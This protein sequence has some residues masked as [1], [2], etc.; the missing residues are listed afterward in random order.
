MASGRR[1]CIA[2]VFILLTGFLLS[3]CTGWHS[4]IPDSA[5]PGEAEARQ[6]LFEL[7]R[8]NEGLRSFKGLGKIRITHEDASRNIRLAW[9]GATGGKLRLE[10]LSVLGQPIATLASDGQW[11][12]IHSYARQ[13]FYKTKVSGAELKNLIGIPISSQDVIDLLTGHPPV[14]SY[15]H[16]ALFRDATW[17]GMIIELK[18]RWGNLSERLYLSDAKGGVSKIEVY[19]RFKSLVYACVFEEMNAVDGFRVPRILTIFAPKGKSVQLTIERYWANA[20]VA[21]SMFVLQRP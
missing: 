4:Q 8:T 9:V 21:S 16:A 19:D 1:N 15:H 6:R 13:R 14:R 5:G 2:A 12:F 20:P 18:T 11:L 3:S 10:F 17:P 7:S